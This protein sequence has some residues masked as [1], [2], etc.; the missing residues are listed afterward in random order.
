MLYLFYQKIAIEAIFLHRQ[1]KGGF[2]APSFCYSS[3]FGFLGINQSSLVSSKEYRGYSLEDRKLFFYER[4]VD[5]QTF[6]CFSLWI[7]YILTN[8]SVNI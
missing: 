4:I 5:D 3:D 8:K 7:K 1:Q 6:Y 2:R